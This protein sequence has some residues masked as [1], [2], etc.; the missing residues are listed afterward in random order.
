[1]F[2]AT[3]VLATALGAGGASRSHGS[4]PACTAAAVRAIEHHVPL[5]SVSAACR[6]L[7]RA[8]LNF[9]LG[10]AIFDVAGA[11]HHKPAWRR[12]AVAAGARLARLIE[13]GR[14]PAGAIRCRGAPRH[15]AP[16][17]R[18]AGGWA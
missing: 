5:T 18:A 2:L 7:S 1:M 10:R 14:R 6:S 8:E 11:G 3:G 12:R 15:P 16:P 9:A 4:V 17:P 13:S